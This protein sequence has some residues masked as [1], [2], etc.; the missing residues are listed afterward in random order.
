MKDLKQFNLVVGDED[1]L[2]V[3]PPVAEDASKIYMSKSALAQAR[4]D[5]ESVNLSRPFVIAEVGK[6]AEAAGFKRG[7][8]VFTKNFTQDVSTL[9]VFDDERRWHNPIVSPTS[10]IAAKVIYTEEWE[11]QY[12]EL[13]D[14]VEEAIP[15]RAAHKEK[16]EANKK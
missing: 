2:L 5:S 4:R 6:V 14:K 8:Y 11:N 1:V 9:I 10:C 3:A 13:I 7:D 16:L 15:V 12:N